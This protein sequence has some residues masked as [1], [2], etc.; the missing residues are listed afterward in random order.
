MTDKSASV[1]PESALSSQGRLRLTAKVAL[2]VSLVSTLVLL[3]A[4]YFLLIDSSQKDYI[5]TIMSLTRSQQQLAIAMLVGAALIF[6]L[7]GLLTWLFTLYFSHRIAGPIYRFSRNLEMEISEGPVKT[8]DIRKEDNFQALSRK[9][10][11]TVAGLQQRFNNQ[12]TIVDQIENQIDSDL[13]NATDE[14]TR[15][16]Q[17]LRD[18]ASN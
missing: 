11:E 9:L 14:F 3:T 2:S 5:Q 16:L 4:L 18:A 15:L 1:D 13:P 17:K 6:S 10:G 7:S 8:V 12:L